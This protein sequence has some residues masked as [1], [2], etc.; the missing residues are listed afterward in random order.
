M[1]LRTAAY[2]RACMNWAIGKEHVS[3]SN[4]FASL[5]LSTEENSRE[6]V[7]TDGELVEIWKPPRN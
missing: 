4:P 5:K 3:G 6:R 2:G 7:L 1:A